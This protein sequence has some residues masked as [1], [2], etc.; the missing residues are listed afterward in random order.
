MDGVSQWVLIEDFDFDGDR[1][2]G[3]NFAEGIHLNGPASWSS[4]TTYAANDQVSYAM[5]CWRTAR[6]RRRTSE[7]GRAGAFLVQR[8]R[9]PAG[10]PKVD[11]KASTAAAFENEG[12][13]TVSILGPSLIRVAS[14]VTVYGSSGPYRV[15]SEV[16]VETTP[17]TS[18]LYLADFLT[19]PPT[20]V[21]GMRRLNSAY[22]GPP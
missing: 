2:S 5:R 10:T 22:A 21:F 11:G 1:Q 6:V 20:I 7:A 15:D 17:V 8:R 19:V 16:K 14:G 4:G 13:A 3:D 12:V 18:K 9:R